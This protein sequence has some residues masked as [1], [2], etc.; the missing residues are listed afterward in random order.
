MAIGR[1][2]VLNIVTTLLDKAQTQ[3]TQNLGSVVKDLHDLRQILINTRQEIGATLPGD[4]TDKHLQVA[5]DELDAVVEATE[6]AS[7]TIMDCC[8]V[9]QEHTASLNEDVRTPIENAVTQIFEACSFQDITGQRIS[10]V[11][12]ALKDIEEKVNHIFAI[13]GLPDIEAT[14]QANDIADK[15]DPASLLNGPQLKGQGV[16]QDDIDKL[17]SEFDN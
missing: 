15:D 4:I 17:L 9:I 8:E 14:P 2:Q 3:N 16:S 6:E 5:S 10:K 11:V 13:L 12:G 1:E 7:G